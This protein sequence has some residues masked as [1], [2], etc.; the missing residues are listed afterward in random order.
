MRW[1][2]K[3]KGLGA[4]DFTK[5]IDKNAERMLE[6]GRRTFRHDTFG[7]EEAS[8]RRVLNS[9]GAGKFDAELLLDGKAFRPDGKSAATLIPPAFGL[10]GVNLHTW[11]G[12]GSVIAR[13]GI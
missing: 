3:E 9:W 7:D 1:E 12:W 6:E 4:A 8:V 13:K 10:A 11:T 5:Q 2:Q